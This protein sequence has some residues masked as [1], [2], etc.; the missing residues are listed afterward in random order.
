MPLYFNVH[1]RDPIFF[2]L[3]YKIAI[4]L[5]FVVAVS[6]M[7]L[8]NPGPGCHE[9]LI[10]FF[11]NF[12]GFVNLNSISKPSPDLNITKVTEFQAN[13]FENVPDI[14][15]HNETWLKLSINSR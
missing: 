7:S 13:T 4:L 15:I 3:L 2:S 14:I 8:L 12:Q 1:R 10:C 11:H 9:G 6:N 5:L